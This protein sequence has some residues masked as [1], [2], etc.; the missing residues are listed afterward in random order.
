MAKIIIVSNRLPV[1]VGNVIK[2][3]PGGLVSALSGVSTNNTK[4]IWIGWAGTFS[5]NADNSAKLKETLIKDFDC[6]PVFLSKKEISDYYHGFSNACLWPALH[7]FSQHIHYSSMFWD[8]Y[9]NINRKFAEYIAANAADD[10]LVWIHDYHLFLVPQMLR[11]IKPNIKIG[12]F[13]HTP[14]PSFEVFRCLPH[15]EEILKGLLGSDLV[16]FHTYGYLRHFRRSCLRLLNIESDIAQILVDKRFC[17]LGVFPIGINSDQFLKELGT[18]RFIKRR[19]ELKKAYA[20]YKVVLSVERVDY[21]KG[22]L[23][24]LEAIEKFLFHHKHKLDVAFIF[25]GIPTRGEVKE[26]KELLGQIQKKV[27]EIN[28]QYSNIE[29][30]PI[31]FIHKTIPLSD[32]CALYSIADVAMITPLIDGMNLVA[33]EYLACKIDS[34]GVLLLSEFAGA[35]HELISAVLVN[36]YD[37]DNVTKNLENALLMDEAEKSQRLIPMRSH[38]IRYNANQWA[39]TFLKELKQSRKSIKKQNNNAKF[40][41][42]KVLSSIKKAKKV[43]FFIDYDGTLREFEDTPDKAKPTKEILQIISALARHANYEV[44]IISGRKEADLEKWFKG[45]NVA[46]ISEHGYSILLP[47]SDKWQMINSHIDL[48]WKKKVIKILSQY[49][50]TPQGTS[51]EEKKSSVVWHYRQADPEF[52]KWKSQQLLGNLLEILTNENVV[53]SQGNHIVEVSSSQIN[54]G[55][56]VRHFMQKNNY[57]LIVCAGDDKTDETMFQIND[58]RIVSIKIGLDETFARYKIADPIL[59]REFLLKFTKKENF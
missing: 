36:P 30:T 49:V 25:I 53:V 38:V 48:S 5:S 16:G 15:R 14:F 54:K 33:K 57:D 23:R 39:Q 32:L 40:I 37:I 41:S 52:G 58:A 31:H 44:F 26:Y 28:S 19:N 35:A 17:K 7:Y 56:A 24:R 55:F 2:K 51:I 20:N 27:G 59:F 3:S 21:T 42:E 46:L 1:T 43:A 12:F 50:S 47:K 4:M 10:D 9:V 22:I 8:S 18:K 34:T 13:L 45:L 11:K 6:Y 29:Y